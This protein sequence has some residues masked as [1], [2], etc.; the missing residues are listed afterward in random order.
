LEAFWR[1]HVSNCFL[2]PSS[3]TR[4]SHVRGSDL[5][6]ELDIPVSDCLKIRVLWSKMEE[7]ECKVE[8]DRNP[9]ETRTIQTCPASAPSLQLPAD[10]PIGCRPLPTPFRRI[11]PFQLL[12]LRISIVTASHGCEICRFIFVLQSHF[13]PYRI[14]RSNFVF[15][16]SRPSAKFRS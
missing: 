12:Q 14:R 16:E 15:L 6:E 13:R 3:D 10:H 1:A 2:L 9:Q 4:S 11:M 7:C 5:A 8:D